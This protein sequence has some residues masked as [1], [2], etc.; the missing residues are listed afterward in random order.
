MNPGAEYP[1]R[2]SRSRWFGTKGGLGK[3]SWHGRRNVV[4]AQVGGGEGD[5]IGIV[6][7][8]PK[9]EDLVNVDLHDG[10]R[11]ALI[12]YSLQLYACG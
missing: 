11:V 4:R 7:S 2:G 10:R 9:A 8:F 6:E 12:E 1:G 5:H 3:D